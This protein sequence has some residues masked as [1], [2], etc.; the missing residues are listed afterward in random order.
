[1]EI[2]QAGDEQGNAGGRGH[3]GS[4]VGWGGVGEGGILA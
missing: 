4:L 3:G 1:M 2:D